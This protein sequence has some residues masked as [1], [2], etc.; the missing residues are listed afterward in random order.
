MGV[1]GGVPPNAG[2]LVVLVEICEGFII[3]KL[4][5]IQVVV[6]WQKGTSHYLSQWWCS[7]L[8]HKCIIRPQSWVSS[9]QG[10]PC[11]SNMLP[12]LLITFHCHY[13]IWGCMCSTGPF[14]LKWLRGYIYSSMLFSS[15]NHKYQPYPLLSYFSVVVCLRCLLHHILSLIAYTFWEYRDFV[16]IVVVQFMMSSNSGMRFCLQIVFICI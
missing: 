16:F 4:T 6:W 1:G 5:L 9:G 13:N 12:V 3:D 8:N 11:V 15:S 10:T 7:G 14:Q 2:V